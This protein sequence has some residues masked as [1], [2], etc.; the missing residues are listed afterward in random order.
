MSTYPRV[1]EQEN[2]FYNMMTKYRNPKNPRIEIHFYT[3][4]R[5]DLQSSFQVFTTRPTDPDRLEQRFT[6]R[7]KVI[8]QESVTRRFLHP[9]ADI[10]FPIYYPFFFQIY[11]LQT[12]PCCLSVYTVV[13]E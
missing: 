6:V 5:Q 11:K 7:W 10:S 8:L 4:K 2:S 9:M 12:Q 13:S 3:E 1:I